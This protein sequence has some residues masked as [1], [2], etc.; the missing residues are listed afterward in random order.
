MSNTFAKKTFG[1]KYSDLTNEEK[2]IV[3]LQGMAAASG[4][5][6]QATIKRVQELS[7]QVQQPDPDVAEIA[8]RSA[9]TTRPV[10]TRG[11]RDP[12]A[13]PLSQAIGSETERGLTGLLAQQD[14]AS[15]M[16][17]LSDPTSQRI[18]DYLGL[19]PPAQ[20]FITREEFDA[21]E[22]I[23][24]NYA[25]AVEQI[26]LD[27]SEGLSGIGDLVKEAQQE[28]SGA[29]EAIGAGIKDFLDFQKSGGIFG[30]LFREAR[31][32]M[33]GDIEEAFRKQYGDPEMVRAALGDAEYARLV[34][35]F[36]NTVNA[37]NVI[38]DVL[39][40]PGGQVLTDAQGNPI[41]QLPDTP[42]TPVVQ[43][44]GTQVPW[45]EAPGVAGPVRTPIAPVT[46]QEFQNLLQQELAPTPDFTKTF[47]PSLLSGVPLPSQQLTG[48]LAPRI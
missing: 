32:G 11:Q 38:P 29:L 40:G 30:N 35:D 14:P 3:A 18:L 44:A 33:R 39:T 19:T 17:R 47:Q 8:Q 46:G 41:Q 31:F 7:Q 28:D 27:I 15:V 5:A 23:E 10:I 24:R 42:V 25:D 16:R 12:I 48:L 26:G 45:W 9:P 21:R 2:Q 6:N 4:G 22:A 1:K 43:Q 13:T 20:D 37:P 36:R 34:S